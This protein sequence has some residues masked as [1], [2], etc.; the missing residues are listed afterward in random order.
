MMPKVSLLIPVYNVE[1]TLDAALASA[2]NQTLKEIEILCVDD[3]STD[4]SPEILNQ[5]AARDSRIIL[6]RHEQNKGLFSARKTAAEKAAGQYLMFLDSDD[7]L[8]PN[9]CEKAFRTIESRQTEIFHF[10]TRILPGRKIPL[11]N[12]TLIRR[13]IR[14]YNGFLKE[15]NIFFACFGAYPQ[16][17]HCLCDKII[18]SAL[19]RQAYSLLQEFPLTVYEDLYLYFT[20]ALLAHSYY[21][22]N[23]PLYNYRFAEGICSGT[24]REISGKQFE[25]YCATSQ[26][27]GPLK[28][29]LIDLKRTDPPYRQALYKVHTNI[30]STCFEKFY[31]MQSPEEWKDL[32]VQTWFH[33]D[34]LLF[35]ATSSIFGR[36]QKSLSVKLGLFL[37]WI[38]RKILTILTGRLY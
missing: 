20:I 27:T 5:H 24:T 3:G 28:K 36:Y 13:F 18:S 15:E 22:E 23:I 9:A 12:R 34:R 17:D 29:L 37:T 30:L 35:E 10:G 31:Q 1:S 26:I 7:T 14:P 38:P 16:Y 8:N 2:E 4:R 21:G 6:L 33:K 19:C 25:Q 32:F 11:R